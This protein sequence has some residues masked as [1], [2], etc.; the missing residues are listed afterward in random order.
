MLAGHNKLGKECLE[1]SQKPLQ[2]IASTARAEVSVDM[3]GQQRLQSLFA[4]AA[5]APVT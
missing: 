3:D 1:L 4:V 2:A 5:V